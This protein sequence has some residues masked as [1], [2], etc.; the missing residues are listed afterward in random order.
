MISEYKG[1]KFLNLACG[2]NFIINEKW[3]NFDF[4]KRKGVNQINLLEKLPIDSQSVDVVYCSHFIEH[5]PE[6]MVSSFLNECFRVLKNNGTLRLVLPDFEKMVREY[7]K[8][9]DLK[10]E[11]KAEFMMVSIIDQFVRK[12]SGGKLSHIIKKSIKSDDQELK[13]YITERCGDIFKENND[14][15]PM[16]D[17]KLST[18]I[19]SMAF[20]K[21]ISLVTALLPKSFRDQNVSMA[22]VGELHAWIYDSTILAKI[23]CEIGFKNIEEVN[24]NYTTIRQFPMTL[25]VDENDA[26]RKGQDSIFLEARK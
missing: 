24:Y 8:M 11:N 9:R 19:M 1:T 15:H 23:L 5:I 10:M 6:H 12:K 21:Y 17:R 18:K 14:G 13:K 2:E 4:I 26:P 3:L 7:I 25:D 20:R 16:T 22:E